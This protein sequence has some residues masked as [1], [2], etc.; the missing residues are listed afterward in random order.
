MMLMRLRKIFLRSREGQQQERGRG[1]RRREAEERGRKK[2]KVTLWFRITGDS[3]TSLLIEL[4]P[5][6]RKRNTR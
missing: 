1:R 4:G 5:E 3:R 2:W 6:D